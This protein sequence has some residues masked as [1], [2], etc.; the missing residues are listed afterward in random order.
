MRDV[1]C[2]NR[3]PFIVISQMVLFAKL[4]FFDDSL[5][6]EVFGSEDVR[7]QSDGVQLQLLESAGSGECE[8]VQ[9]VRSQAKEASLE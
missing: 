7:I 8:G 1:H 3:R 2:E 6:R 5:C 4:N 9:P